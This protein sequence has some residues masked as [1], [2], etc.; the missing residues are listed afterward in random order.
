MPT[1]TTTRLTP[2][3]RAERLDAAH[4]DLAEAVQSIRSGA[5]W[6]RWLRVQR[7]LHNYSPRNSMWLSAQAAMRGSDISAVAGYRAWQAQGRQVRAGERGY[8]VLA[9]IAYR[10]R[11]EEADPA[12]RAE[13]DEPEPTREVRGFGVAH[14]WDIGQTDGPDLPA[15][16]DRLDGVAPAELLHGL[17]AEIRFRGFR[18]ETVGAA[19]GSTWCGHT[20]FRGQVVAVREGLSDLHRAKTLCHELAHISLHAPPALET[21]PRARM[22]VE[23]ESTAYLVLGEAGLDSSAYS[24]DYVASWA[25]DPSDVLDAASRAKTCAAAILDVAAPL[26]PAPEHTTRDLVAGANA[27]PTRDGGPR[28]HVVMV[29]PPADLAAPPDPAIVP[30][31]PAGLDGPALEL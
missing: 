6:Q 24:F 15:A 26:P 25:R 23:A 10:R 30:P 2:E 9:P 8:S 29:G 16:P 21:M 27:V 18:I 20:D 28:V 7:T 11:V 4:R 1:R 5:D 31:E 12:Q 22:E 14:V 19:D 17:E 13:Q 3:Q